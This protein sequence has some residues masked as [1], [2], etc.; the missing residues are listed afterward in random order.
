MQDPCWSSQYITDPSACS[1]TPP[2]APTPV[3]P[4]QNNTFAINVVTSLFKLLKI[5]DKDASTCVK[6]VGNANMYFKHFAADVAGKNYSTAMFDISR[7]LNSL[8]TSLNDCGTQEVQNKL[9]ALAVA[10]KWA[11][12]ST[13]A[14]DKT[15]AI[16]VGDSDLWQDIEALATAV[17]AKDTTAIGDS[18]SALL[19]NWSSVTGGCT[20]MGNST[21]CKFMDGLLHILSV[22]AEQIAPCEAFVAGPLQNLTAGAASFKSEDYKLAVQEFLSGLDGVSRT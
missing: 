12:I 14:L 17:G 22:S 2:P 3:P 15:V 10:I 8:S 16:L 21:T 11:N 20:A 19:D 6:D 9:D 4:M 13:A 18:L 1:S 7:G 5:T